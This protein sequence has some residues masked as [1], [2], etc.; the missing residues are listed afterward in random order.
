MRSAARIVLALLVPAIGFATPSFAAER[1]RIEGA[2]CVVEGGAYRL[3]FRL[4]D[5]FTPEMTQAVDAGV[6]TTFTFA[7]RIMRDV[8]G[9]TDERVAEFAVRRT[10][11]YDSL[12]QLYTVLLGESATTLT[13]KT[14]N[15]ARERMLVFEGLPIATVGALPASGPLYANVRAEMERI[16][17]PDFPF[18]WSY[19]FFFAPIFE[20]KTAWTRVDLPLAPA[21]PPPAAPTPE[22]K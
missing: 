3:S 11:H 8:S 19:V 12:R 22:A 7:V 5:V 17:L 18:D 14:A 16:A 15:E 10:L 21:S 9:W 20:F 2:V 6:P 13:F 1:A 4:S